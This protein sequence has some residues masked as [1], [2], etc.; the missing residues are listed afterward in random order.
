MNGSNFVLSQ[1]QK[2]TVRWF[3][4]NK[5]WLFL[6]GT[7]RSGKSFG[8]DLGWLL[9]TQ[10]Q[11]EEPTDFILAGFSVGSVRRNV[12]PEIQKFAEGLGMSWKYY[13]LGTYI[14]CGK[15]RYHI[16][17]S[18]DA[19]SEEAVRGMTAGGAY[20]DEMTLMHQSFISMCVTRCSLRGA[21]LIASM[22]PSY[23]MHFV[24][25]EYIDRAE[26]LNGTHMKFGFPDN[27]V[28][29]P[30]YIRGLERV[31]TGAD[32]KRMF[33]GEWVANAG[34]VYPEVI[35][36]EMVNSE[37]YR[38]NTI[39]IDYST[40]GIASFLLCR[41]DA[42]NR[43]LVSAEWYH[44]GGGKGSSKQ[45]TDSELV[46]A[47]GEFVLVN[48]LSKDRVSI[49]PDPSAASFKR[50][51]RKKGW[52]VRSANNDILDG[53]RVTGVALKHGYIRVA[54]QCK[55]LLRELGTYLWD[56]KACE[57]GEDKPLKTDV[58]HGVDALRYYAMKNY[59]SLFRSEPIKKPIGW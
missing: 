34:L 1:K 16:F 56:E 11:F 26:E 12:L 5:R 52:N 35:K 47:L 20:F 19:D 31:L 25:L 53:V 46:A 3:A 27:P 40:S 41:K 9:W 14:Q 10:G 51:C 13:H 8:L 54:P 50:E 39:A 45:L 33:L 2:E 6:S 55:E 38:K 59:K 15:H 7:V 48:G 49:L 44:N 28:L 29:D 22:N 32:Y 42:K 24:K 57:K 17:G 58:H 36:A 18:R 43:T 30:E 23:P 4:G 37:T 21:K